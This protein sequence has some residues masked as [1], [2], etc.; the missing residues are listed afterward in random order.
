[1]RQGRKKGTSRPPHDPGL[2]KLV[3]TKRQWSKPVSD[4]T[5]RQGFAGWHERGYL[6][7]RDEQGLTQ[8][9]TFR[10]TDAFPKALRSEWQHLLE[11][12]DN[13][14]KHKLLERY[15]DSGHGECW[16]RR[17]DIAERVEGALQYFH[18]ERYEL[19]AWVVMPNHVH[20]LFKLENVPM[21]SILE[22]WKKHTAQNANRILA[23]RGRFWQ[24][25]YWD[26]FMRDA[27]H[28]CSI[29]QYIESNPVKAGLVSEPNL[30]PWSSARFRDD[31][32]RL[33]I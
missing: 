13:Y 16:L 9:V 4:A 31:Y 17:T 12:E 28:E 24:A 10:L 33:Q 1:M 22:S 32:G 3:Q 2:Y 11:I 6:P 18:R 30:W 26:T 29:R 21:S 5:L 27:E 8:F 23:S 14:E 25:G 7:H 15:L 20:V 19:R